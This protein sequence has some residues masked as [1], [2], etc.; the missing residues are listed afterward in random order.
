VILELEEKI[1]S[2][3]T[4]LRTAREPVA[5][6]TA[7]AETT[8]AAPEEP[9]AAATVASPA[10]MGGESRAEEGASALTEETGELQKEKESGEGGRRDDRIR[11]NQILSGNSDYAIQVVVIS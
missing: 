7:A 8:L 6:T 5:T 1:T 10:V 4:E 11:E 3:G 2:L 9:A